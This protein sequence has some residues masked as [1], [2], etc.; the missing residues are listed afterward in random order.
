[1][2]VKRKCSD[3]CKVIPYIKCYRKLSPQNSCKNI[4]QKCTN[5]VR[6]QLWQ[7]KQGTTYTKNN[8]LPTDQSTTR[9]VKGQRDKYNNGEN[10]WFTQRNEH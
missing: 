9:N 6:D 7:N 1:M 4:F 8:S 10:A 5:N 3:I 2:Q